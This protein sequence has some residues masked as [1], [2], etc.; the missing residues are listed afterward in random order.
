[1]TCPMV[2]LRTFGCRRFKVYFFDED[3]LPYRA[4]E[5]RGMLKYLETKPPRIALKGSDG[6]FASAAALEDY[7][8]IKSPSCTH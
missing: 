4:A 8:S 5:L 1:M 3:I 6:K 7:V 2:N